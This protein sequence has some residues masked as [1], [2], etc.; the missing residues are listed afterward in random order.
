MRAGIRAVVAGA[1]DCVNIREQPTT[2]AGVR[3]CLPDGARLRVIEGPVSADGYMW[4][5]LEGLGWAVSSYLTPLA[6]T[7]EAGGRA[8]VV[9]GRGDCLNTRSAPAMAAPRGACLTDG[10][11]VRL[12]TGPFE[13]DGMTW[14]QVE[15]GGWV[16]GEYLVAEEQ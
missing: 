7:L 2:G 3:Q 1:G 4:W 9:A 6:P 11:V 14:W 12:V 10:S 15:S 13:A 8:R 16:A 5:R